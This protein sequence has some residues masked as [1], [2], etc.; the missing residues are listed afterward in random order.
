[1]AHELRLMLLLSDEVGT[2]ARRDAEAAGI[3]REAE[4]R[5]GEVMR[6]I[7]GLMGSGSE[8]AGVSGNGNGSG[9]GMDEVERRKTDG[10]EE[11]SSLAE[12]RGETGAAQKAPERE[13]GGQEA[14]AEAEDVDEDDDSDEFEEL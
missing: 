11:R 7:K 1:M 6:R 5:R 14:E 9:V 2:A 13:D 8:D 3:A 12:D 10:K 4:E